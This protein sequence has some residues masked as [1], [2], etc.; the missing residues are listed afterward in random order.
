MTTLKTERL[1]LRPWTDND[2]EPFFILNSDPV[3]MEYFE[4]PLSREE[5]D[6]AVDRI[7]KHFEEKGFGL[8][9]MESKET[10]EFIGTTGIFIPYFEA[11][12]TPCVEIGWRM[13]VKYWGQGLVSEAARASLKY[14]FENVETEEIVAVTVPTNFRS[15][16][17]MD[18][19]GMTH[20]P[21]ADFDHPRVSDG[22]KYK[23]HVLYRLKKT[24]WLK[25]LKPN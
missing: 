23:R 18:R 24:E 12:Y 6:T 5:S 22:H 9:V 11:A 17:V 3:A 7:M 16:A 21:K 8:W 25:S 13:G 20:D 19:L 4:K 2:R 14:G 15:R 10:G 1:I